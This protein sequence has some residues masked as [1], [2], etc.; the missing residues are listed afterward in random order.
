MSNCDKFYSDGAYLP[1]EHRLL[2][3]AW[4]LGIYRRS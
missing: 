2:G 3:R 4:G 1:G